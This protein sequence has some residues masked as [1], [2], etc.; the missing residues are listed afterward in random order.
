MNTG[1]FPLVPF[2]SLKRAIAAMEAIAAQWPGTRYVI[3]EGS[4]GRR[5]KDEWKRKTLEQPVS[6]SERR[7]LLYLLNHTPS[8]A[9]VEAHIKQ[10]I[11]REQARNE[12]RI[13]DKRLG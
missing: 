12:Q 2:A 9:S 6:R 11:A 5:T 1:W 13:A 10:Q 3:N 8:V 4:M 7:R